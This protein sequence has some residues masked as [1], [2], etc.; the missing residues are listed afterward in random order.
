[1]PGGKTMNRILA[2]M[3]AIEDVTMMT[4]GRHG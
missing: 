2:S 4:R 3:P 1:M